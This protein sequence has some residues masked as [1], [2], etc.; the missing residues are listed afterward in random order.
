MT[1]TQTPS[2][3]L[4]IS[5]WILQALLAATLIWAAALKLGKSPNELAAMWPWAGEVSPTLVKLTGIADLLGGIGLV[6]PALLR[7]K[8]V[9]TPIAALGIVVLMICAGVFHI[10]R[11]EASQIGFNIVVAGIAG[12]IAWGR[13]RKRR[14]EGT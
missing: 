2:K 6:L 1:N 3:A 8:P 13:F 10:A 5:L 14:Q 7:V 12:F 9:L 11:G 4:H